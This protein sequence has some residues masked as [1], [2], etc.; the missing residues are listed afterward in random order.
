MYVTPL[1]HLI[2][3]VGTFEFSGLELVFRVVVGLLRLEHCRWAAPVASSW[4]RLVQLAAA[5]AEPTGG[6][7]RP[8]LAIVLQQRWV[9]L[10]VAGIVV[11]W[12]SLASP[13]R[14]LPLGYY[15]LQGTRPTRSPTGVGLAEQ[16]RCSLVDQT[17][18]AA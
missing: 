16:L 8:G 1:G 7:W 2:P 13:G 9:R 11:A 15:D 3:S 5:T 14:P 6:Q 17:A 18:V 10:A 4:Q 12:R